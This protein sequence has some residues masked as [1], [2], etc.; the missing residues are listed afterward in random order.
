MEPEIQGSS[1]LLL[2]HAVQLQGGRPTLVRHAEAQGLRVNTT[3]L[4]DAEL[5][6]VSCQA[7]W[8]SEPSGQAAV[9]LST[10]SPDCCS[11]GAPHTEF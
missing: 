1:T 8:P 3:S 7:G 5:I 4:T 11:I 10:P 9:Q 2:Q 6:L